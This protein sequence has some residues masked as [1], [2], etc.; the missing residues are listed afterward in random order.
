[1]P[2]AAPPSFRFR[3]ADGGE[4]HLA[5][6]AEEHDA[7]GGIAAKLFGGT[8]KSAWGCLGVGGIPRTAYYRARLA[9]TRTA[10]YR[11]RLAGNRTAYYR[12]RL[13]CF[14]LF[15][16]RAQR[17]DLLGR[18]VAMP[19]RVDPKL[20]NRL[21]F[22][23]TVFLNLVQHEKSPLVQKGMIGQGRGE[24]KGIAAA[25]PRLPAYR[26]VGVRKQ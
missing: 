5:H 23:Q 10:Y 25:T 4:D 26:F 1:V 21:K 8:P 9:G 15:K 3:S 16:P 20:A 17:P 12:A 6:V 22:F 2:W 13:A 11:A 19:V 7:S 24:V 14:P 18:V